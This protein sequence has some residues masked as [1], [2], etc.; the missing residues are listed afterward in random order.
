M[1]KTPKTLFYNYGPAQA[2][3]PDFA[4]TQ[5]ERVTMLSYDYGYSHIAVADTGQSGYVATEDLAPAPPEATPSPTPPLVASRSR[6]HHGADSRPPTAEEESEI[7]LPE[8]PETKPP[9][10]APRFRY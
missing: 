9:S 2:S 5:G 4:L 8:F 6:R 7:P 1:V 3:G 10:T